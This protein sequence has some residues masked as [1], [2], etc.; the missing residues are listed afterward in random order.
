MDNKTLVGIIIILLIG[1]GG[2]YYLN[3]NNNEAPVQQQN[4]EWNQWQNNQN[5]NSN[6]NIPIED[7]ASPNPNPSPN[8]LSPKSY[9]EALSL[10]K[11]KDAK[12]FLYF[13]TD[14]C[15]YCKQMKSQTFSDPK[16]KEKLSQYIIYHCNAVKERSVAVKYG[17]FGV[18]V[19]FV[20]DKNETKLKEGKGFKSSDK[21]ITWLDDSENIRKRTF[22]SDE[23]TPFEL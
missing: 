17:I 22:N 4:P 21:F 14:S 7:Q 10:A 18:P 9:E 15:G 16:V 12:I 1:I 19:Y 2:A 23:L 13:E 3:N 11:T 5:S 8:L 20:I 6:P